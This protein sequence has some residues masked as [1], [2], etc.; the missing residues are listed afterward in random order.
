MSDEGAAR[1]SLDA[2]R[3][4]VG[5]GSTRSAQDGMQDGNETGRSLQGLWAW[6]YQTYRSVARGRI[7]QLVRVP[8]VV[9]AAR[10]R[11]NKTLDR[12][13]EVPTAQACPGR[14]KVVRVP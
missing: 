5:E 11:T 14:A 2:S 4:K 6:R 10:R 1:W 9:M 7:R 12:P 13:V 8:T 3:R